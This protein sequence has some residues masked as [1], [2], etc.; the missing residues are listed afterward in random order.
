M[1]QAPGAYTTGYAKACGVDSTLANNYIRHTRLGDPVLDPVMDDVAD[2]DGTS[3]SRFI[4]AG[5]EHED[6]ELRL[7]PRSLR[8]FFEDAVGV[9][10]WVDF[11]SHA[12]AVRAFNLNAATMLVAFVAGVLIEGF[13]TLISKSFVTTGRVLTPESARRRLQ[14]NNRQLMEV[15]YPGGLD[16]DGDGWKKSMR[17]RFVHA[18]VR[19]L[20][21]NSGAWDLEEYGTPISAAHMGLALTVF[22]MRLLDHAARVG[23]VFNDEEQAGVMHVWR[24]A[25]YVM[26]VPMDMLYEDREHARRIHSIGHMCEPPPQPD[27]ATMANALIGAIPLTAGIEGARQQRSVVKLAYRLSRALIGDELAD[28]LR[29]PK[30]RTLGSLFAFRARQK[31]QRR[32]QGRQGVRLNNFEQLLDISVYDAADERYRMPDHYLSARS[33]PW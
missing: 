9:P 31:L 25:G 22:S 13:S 20:I 29:F 17:V 16:L 2:L 19:H 1:W 24:Y 32:W 12:P 33:R 3:L 4:R 15:F 5:I 26:G 30:M 8:H 14:Q 18:R 11:G 21:A 27:A 6:A 7:A 23:A 28:Q 10:S